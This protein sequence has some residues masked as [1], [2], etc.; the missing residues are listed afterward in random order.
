MRKN[1]NLERPIRFHRIATRSSAPGPKASILL[2]FLSYV[3]GAVFGGF[4]AWY[5]FT[6]AN[7]AWQFDDLST[8]TLRFPMWIYYASLP[9]GAA[10]MTL[11]YVVLAFLCLTPILRNSRSK[12]S[13]NSR[14]RAS[15]FR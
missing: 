9:V 15:D 13:V 12:R 8:T 4:L 6:A 2:E 1:K 5:G 3:C 10:L 7:D 11:R 14:Q